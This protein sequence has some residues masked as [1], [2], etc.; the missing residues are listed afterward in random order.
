[1]KI[2]PIISL[3][4]KRSIMELFYD[5]DRDSQ[6]LSDDKGIYLIDEFPRTTTAQICSMYDISNKIKEKML[7][8]DKEELNDILNYKDSVANESIAYPYDI[9]IKGNGETLV[10]FQTTDGVFC[11][12]ADYLKPLSNIPE[13][14]LFYTIRKHKNGYYLAVKC[15]LFLKALIFLTALG[16][17]EIETLYEICN[18]STL[19]LK[20]INELKEPIPFPSGNKDIDIEKE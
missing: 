13:E 1:M 5:S 6:W 12:N 9:K 8:A 7:L 11:I 4:K 17:E 15:G 3:C 14:E 20:K 18:L 10:M 19:A 2:K 16:T